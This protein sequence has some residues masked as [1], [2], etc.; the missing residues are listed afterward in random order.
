MF[1]TFRV[2][3]KRLGNDAVCKSGGNRNT[4]ALKHFMLADQETCKVFPRHFMDL[5]NDT[6]DSGSIGRGSRSIAGGHAATLERGH[7]CIIT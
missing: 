1:F 7:I 5:F 6:P 3:A 2:C 4:K